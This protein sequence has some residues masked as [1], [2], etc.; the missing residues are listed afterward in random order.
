MTISIF[1]YTKRKKIKIKMLK[2]RV[3]KKKRTELARAKYL[4]I[5]YLLVVKKM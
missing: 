2:G 1:I 3:Q 5:V 4:V